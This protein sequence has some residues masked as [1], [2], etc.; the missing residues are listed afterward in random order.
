MTSDWTKLQDT[1]IMEEEDKC[2]ECDVSVHKV[3][4][5]GSA[6]KVGASSYVGWG[7]WTPEHPSF[8]ENGAL[9]G[10]PRMDEC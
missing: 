5:D 10:R 2:H 1:A 4:T 3:C 9:K 7:L 8:D 6:T